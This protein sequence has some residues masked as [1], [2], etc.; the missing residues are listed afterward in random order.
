V[1]AV[2]APEPLVSVVVP[3]Y[4]YGAYV[5]E[6]VRSAL[7]QDADVPLEVVVVD[8]ASSD[9]SVE[10]LR[11]IGDPRMRLWCHERN[12]G[13]VVTI[14]EGFARARGRFIA[15]IDSDDRYRPWFLRETLAVLRARPEVG[16]VWG[17]V[18]LIDPEGR[19]LEERAAGVHAGRDHQGNELLAL[20]ERNFIPAPTVIARR[21]AWAGALPIPPG[22]GF[23]DWYLSLELARRWDFF[24]R[25]RVLADYRVHPRSLHHRMTLDRSEEATVFRLLS[26]LFAEEPRLA[27]QRGRVYGAQC[28]MLADKYFA[29]GMTAD[30]R[31]CYLRALRHRPALARHPGLLRRLGGAV[32]GRRAYEAVKAWVRRGARPGRAVGVPRGGR[33]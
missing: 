3:S 8:D 29:A 26:R 17:D 32:V 15:R 11:A 1:P 23:S 33:P 9:D 2:A 25:G 4:N 7:A 14:N 20:L 16:L 12:Q 21:E 28:L 13:H 5:G 31:R 30:A 19:L 10:V 6:T 18:A 27:G 24:H 22:L